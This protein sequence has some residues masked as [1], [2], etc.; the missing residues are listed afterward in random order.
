[1]TT[2][3][4][5]VTTPSVGDN[6]PPMSWESGPANWNRFAAVNEEFIGIHMDDAVAQRAGFATAIGMGNLQYS[7]MH[8]A[9]RN[10]FGLDGIIEK[11]DIRFK[12]PNVKGQIVT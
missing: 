7:Y 11:V 4:P 9:L 3:G 12:Q 2:N 6:L 1:M 10:W 5:K 8:I